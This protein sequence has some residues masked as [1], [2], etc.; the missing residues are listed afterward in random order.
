MIGGKDGEAETKHYPYP[1]G[2]DLSHFGVAPYQAIS[3]IDN[4]TTTSTTILTGI[5]STSLLSHIT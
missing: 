4:L 2:F 1:S 5:S 3:M